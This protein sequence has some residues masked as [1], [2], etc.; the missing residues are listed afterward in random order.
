MTLLFLI[1]DQVYQNAVTIRRNNICVANVYSCYRRSSSDAT[2]TSTVTGSSSG[3]NDT[4]TIVVLLFV[5]RT[6]WK[7]N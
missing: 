1:Q 6:S 2:N 3:I 5:P 4:I 7:M